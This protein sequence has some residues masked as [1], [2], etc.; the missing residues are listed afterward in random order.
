VTE[1]APAAQLERLSPGEHGGDP[2]RELRRF[3]VAPRPVLDFSVNT[4][5]LGP[6]PRL[7]QAWQ[8]FAGE[9]ERYPSVAGDGVTYFYERRFKIPSDRVLAG[10]GATELLYLAARALRPTRVAVV[11]PSYADYRRAARLAGLETFA[12]PL[13][14]DDDWAPLGLED[15]GRALS[16]ADALLLGNPNNPTGTLF[17]AADL[18]QLAREHPCRSLWVD[19]SFIQLTDGFPATSLA[20]GGELPP[21]VLVF[22]SLT[23]FYS[24]PGLRLGATIGLPEGI[25]RLRLAKEPWTVNRIAEQAARLLAECHDYEAQVR[26]MVARERTRLAALLGRLPSIAVAPTEANFF[27][28]RWL[29]NRGLDD[30]LA[31]LL[32]AG[33][34]VRDC[35][36]FPGLE[37][38][39]FRFAV[40]RPEEND[41]LLAALASAG[42]A[43]ELP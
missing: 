18:F 9:I 32:E 25:A 42:D 43:E 38:N 27:L 11:T 1:T 33:L 40:R 20:F 19:E 16:Q 35:R 34:C 10:N 37:E 5:P 22:H 24:V 26:S 12:V 28:A 13:S 23:K 41:R 36:S 17:A 15:L 21:N 2:E 7:L 39:Y 30:L 3:G 4:S 31:R 6:P 8:E 29:G 14:P